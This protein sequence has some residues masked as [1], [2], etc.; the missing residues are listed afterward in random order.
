MRPLLFLLTLAFAAPLASAQAPEPTVEKALSVVRVNVTNQPWDF[1]RPWGKRPPF[2]RRAIGA[3]LAGERVLVTAELV[4]N[5]NFVE[6]ETAG[7]GQKVPAS[8]EF[9]DYECNLA[10]LKTDDAEFLKALRPIEIAEAK[11]GEQLSVWQIESN[12]NLLVTHGPMTTAEVLRYPVDESPFLVYRLTAQLQFRDTAF[13]LPV[14]KGDKLVG[15]LQRYDNSA[16]NADIIP[17]PVIEHFLKDTAQPPYEGFPRLGMGYSQTRDPQLRRYAGLKNGNGG[18]YVTDVLP[19]G[20]AAKA[21]LLEGDVVLQIDGEPIDQD[22]N[23]NDAQYGRIA[24]SHLV[25][26]RHFHG[27]ELKFD[28]LRKGEPKQIAVTIANRPVTS[29]VIE[30]YVI[31]RAPPFYILGGLVLQELSRQY[32]KEW[33]PDWKKKAPEQFVYLDAQQNELFKDGPKKIVFLSRVLPTGATV[34][35]EEIQSLLVKKI[36]GLALQGISDIP[37]ALALA[38]DGV[39]KLEFD[40][41]PG[42]IYLD[43]AQVTKLEPLLAQKYRLPTMQRLQ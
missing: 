13:P 12:G 20:P 28:I 38:K 18:I 7:G 5:A 6:L 41:D 24:L 26:T 36:N 3:V 22:G 23:Y 25:G 29:Y 8:V 19:G 2:T 32:L 35:Y 37:A 16:N 9:V 21:G 34:G 14:V 17:A 33:G 39:H 27:N 1:G 43:A 15:L 4:A 30:P 31:D 10:L 42:A 11:I 40:G